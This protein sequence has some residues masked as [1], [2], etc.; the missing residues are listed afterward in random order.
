MTVGLGDGD[1]RCA[2]SAYL[3]RDCFALDDAR[4]PHVLCEPH[5]RCLGDCRMGETEGPVRS[6]AGLTGNARG[7]YGSPMLW[8]G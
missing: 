5:R 4:A 6:R 8:L 1:G 3:R 7:R 2:V